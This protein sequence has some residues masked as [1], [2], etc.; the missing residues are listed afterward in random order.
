MLILTKNILLI[1]WERVQKS[2]RNTG[3]TG[4]ILEYRNTK[5]YIPEQ[6]TL[7]P[8]QITPLPEQYNY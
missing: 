2:Y 4:T 6:I 7:L 5:E 8:E 3:T 1:F